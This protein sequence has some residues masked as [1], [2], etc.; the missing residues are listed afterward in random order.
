[1]RNNYRVCGRIFTPCRGGQKTQTG[2]ETRAP[3]RGLAARLDAEFDADDLATDGGRDVNASNGSERECFK[4]G[5]EI[6]RHTSAYKPWD[7][8]YTLTWTPASDDEENVEVSDSG[9]KHPQEQARVFCSR[10]CLDA[11]IQMDYT[12]K[13]ASENGNADTGSER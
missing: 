9:G 1:M 8:I 12:L 7:E 10:D 13:P 5:A 6:R 4:C 2:I 11:F 3:K